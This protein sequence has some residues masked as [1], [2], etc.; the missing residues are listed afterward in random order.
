MRWPP[1]EGARRSLEQQVTASAN[2]RAESKSHRTALTTAVV[3]QRREKLLQEETHLQNVHVEA[4]EA[5][6]QFGNKKPEG[7][8]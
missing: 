1:T 7:H 5:A 6:A 8:P 3:L 4:T 2:L